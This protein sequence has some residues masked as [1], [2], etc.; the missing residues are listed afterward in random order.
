MGD[1]KIGMKLERFEGPRGFYERSQTFLAEHE[2]CHSLMLGL[3][4]Q[5]VEHPEL[6]PWTSISEAG[7]L[8]SWR[9]VAVSGGG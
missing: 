4:E 3:A 8:L 6:S 5:L 2:A 7:K 9:T 1:A